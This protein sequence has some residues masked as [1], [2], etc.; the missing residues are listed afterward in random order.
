MPLTRVNYKI[1][2]SDDVIDNSSGTV[3]DTVDIIEQ[4]SG[5]ISQF[6]WSNGVRIH[7][8]WAVGLKAGYTF[9]SVNNDFTIGNELTQSF[10]VAVKE[11]TYVKDF[12]FA[13]GLSFSQDSVGKGDYRVSAGVSYNFSGNLRT[14]KT[15]VIQRR[16]STGN[17]ISSDTVV[18]KRGSIFV[19]PSLTTGFS[20]SKGTKWSIATEFSFQDWSKFRSINEEDEGL[21][22]TWKVGLGGEFTP[23]LLSFRSYL[24]RI[25]YRAGLS[26]EMTP[27]LVNNNQVKDF[28]INFGL[29]LPTG[30]LSSLDCAFRI[31]KRGNKSENVLEEAYFKVYFGITFN[32][33]WFNKRKFD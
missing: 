6:Y 3:I 26:Y 7:E 22:K 19:P 17:P 10:Y 20:I 25:T 24:K 13:G 30:R 27:Y 15:S 12:M 1:A 33:Q 8:N 21:E 29:A 14:S 11:Q 32:D 31:G 4:G 9:G 23:D 28:G 18:H 16:S 2:Y 5:G